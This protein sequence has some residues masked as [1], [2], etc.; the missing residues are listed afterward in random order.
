MSVQARQLPPALP[1]ITTNDWDLWRDY[2]RKQQ[3]PWRTE[4]EIDA[5]RQAELAQYSRAPV[6]SEQGQYPFKGIKLTRADIEW[7]L[8][9]HEDGRPFIDGKDHELGMEEGLDLRGADLRKIR[10]S[11]LPLRN[12]RAG[13]AQEEWLLAS[14]EQREAAATC[15]QMVDL[16]EA[17]LEEAQL[18]GV[19]LEG[20]DLR[21]A[22]LERADLR[23]AHLATANLRGAHLEGANLCEAHL[24]GKKNFPEPANFRGVFFDATTNLANIILGN[25]QYGFVPLADVHWGNVNLAVVDWAAMTKIGDEYA[26]Q[27]KLPVEYQAA[28]RANRQLARVLREQGLYDHADYFSY[29]AH[30]NLQCMYPQQA[31]LPVVLRVF[32]RE[33]MPLPK[34]LLRLEERRHGQRMPRHPVALAFLRLFPLLLILLLAMLLQPLVLPA[35]LCVCLAAFLAVLPVMRKRAR[36]PPQY[37]RA[38]KAFPPPQL[39]TQQQR[40][41]LQW[42]LLMGFLLGV[43]EAQLSLLLESQLTA[44]AHIPLLQR[45]WS[46]WQKHPLLTTI[47]SFPLILLL[48]LDNAS[49]CYGRYICSLFLNALTGYGYK[50]ARSFYCYVVIVFGFAILFYALGHHPPL[51]ACLLS[52]RSFHGWGF[53]AGSDS[54]SGP[55]VVLAAIEAGMGL[56]IELSI[57]V[58][59]VQRIFAK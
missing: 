4:P 44:L 5:Q 14:D 59:A 53:F 48:L 35:L 19:H 45:L 1:A 58:A 8:T 12:I 25:E 54:S 13:L 47:L 31:L 30:V 29:R 56:I 50:F 38:Q 22:H 7:L 3:H 24:E 41:G 39:L 21:G 23:G 37:R 42:L 46:R 2:W 51:E 52:L 55:L 28:I 17:H 18:C 6:D 57:I 43:P 9:T 26:T 36:H 49:V 27:W 10:L 32:V 15:L 40:R 16:R 11:G 20:A 33:R 34:V